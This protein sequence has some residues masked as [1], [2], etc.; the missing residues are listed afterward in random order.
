MS[1]SK[2]IDKHLV[3]V[4]KMDKNVEYF[5]MIHAHIPPKSNELITDSPKKKFPKSPPTKYFKSTSAGV[6]Y[7]EPSN[8]ITMPYTPVSPEIK[9][10]IRNVSPSTSDSVSSRQY[11]LRTVNTITKPS[12]TSVPHTKYDS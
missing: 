11:N 4:H 1:I 12:N 5:N 9:P 3:R 2:R 8:T 10:L 7:I 6:K